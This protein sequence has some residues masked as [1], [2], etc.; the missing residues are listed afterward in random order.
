M[1][2]CY[3]HFLLFSVLYHI[4][5]NVFFFLVLLEFSLCGMEVVL[6]LIIDAFGQLIDIIK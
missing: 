4:L 1:L 5:E 6:V 2:E 3:F